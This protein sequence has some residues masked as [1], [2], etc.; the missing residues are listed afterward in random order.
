[1][2]EKLENNRDKIILTCKLHATSLPL[3]DGGT[4]LAQSFTLKQTSS[5]VPKIISYQSMEQILC[6][7]AGC[8]QSDTL[9]WCRWLSGSICITKYG[10]R[11]PESGWPFVVDKRTKG[12][13][14]ERDRDLQV[15]ISM[16]SWI[17][18]KYMFKLKAPEYRF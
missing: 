15:R 4:F 6:V 2:I 3:G 7:G 1:M 5:R 18:D 10:S 9:C 11:G 13:T 12:L 17:P 16:M 8:V 14:I